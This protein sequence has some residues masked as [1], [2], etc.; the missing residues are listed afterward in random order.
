MAPCHMVRAR[1]ARTTIRSPRFRE[2]AARGTDAGTNVEE[3]SSTREAVGS[4]EGRVQGVEVI[5]QRPANNRSSTPAERG[6][7]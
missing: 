6:L 1:R 5:N 4:R 7:R 2:K 3:E